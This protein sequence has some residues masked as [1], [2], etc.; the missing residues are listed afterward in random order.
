MS[1]IKVNDLYVFTFNIIS[2]YFKIRF[3]TPFTDKAVSVKVQNLAQN[4]FGLNKSTE[5]L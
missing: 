1:Y 2:D 3:L 4:N 5:W